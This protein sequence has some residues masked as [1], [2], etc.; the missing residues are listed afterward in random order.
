MEA[1]TTSY[2]SLMVFLISVARVTMASSATIP[3]SAKS[4]VATEEASMVPS[5]AM[6]TT[7]TLA[8]WVPV[9]VRMV[10]PTMPVPL[11]SSAMAA[12]SEWEWPSM[13]TSM[14]VT[15]SSR[16]MERLPADSASMPRWPRAMM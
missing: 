9:E 12:W 11:V 15:F 8:N 6:S 16:S 10:S 2:S 4:A 7:P 3:W 13:N 1:K 14:P 5:G